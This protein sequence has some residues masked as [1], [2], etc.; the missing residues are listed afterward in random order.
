MKVVKQFSYPAFVGPLEVQNRCPTRTRNRYC[1]HAIFI[2]SGGSELV[3]CVLQPMIPGMID[4]PR[5][6]IHVFAH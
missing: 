1:E 4:G 6:S 3:R 2:R 5:D